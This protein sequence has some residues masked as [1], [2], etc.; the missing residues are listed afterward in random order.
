MA[1]TKIS[2]LPTFTGNTTGVYVVIDNAGLTETFKIPIDTLLASLSGITT[3]NDVRCKVLISTNA[4]NDEG[5]EIN[6]AKS[7]NSSLSGDTIIDQFVN[8][9]RI[10]ESDGNN[11]GVF[12]DLNK[13]PIGVGGEL[14]W[15]ISGIVN[16]GTFVS[17]DN[18]KVTVTTSGNRGLS[19]AAVSS[20]FTANISGTYGA[21]GGGAGSSLNNGTVNTTPSTSLFN[22]NFIAEG[23]GATYLIFDET[24]SRMYRVTLMI[25]SAY[26]NNFIS[27]ERLY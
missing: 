16:A 12:I 13:A 8:K 20:T 15:K 9:V 18:L 21:S 6:L 25:G 14:I 5:G 3:P 11:R 1:N 2:A 7:P 26:N 4:I 23:D 24:N 17:L 10:F 27:I 22:W 19:I